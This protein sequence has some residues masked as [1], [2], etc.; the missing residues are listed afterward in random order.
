ML[1]SLSVVFYGLAVVCCCFYDGKPI[2]FTMT[3]CVDGIV[4]CTRA[5][6]V[7]FCFWFYLV[8]YVL[9]NLSLS[10]FFERKTNYMY[11]MRLS[12]LFYATNYFLA[13]FV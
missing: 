4:N 6:E 1:C 2:S 11:M 13:G 9:V 12:L 8:K 3:I 10:L 5:E 7:Q